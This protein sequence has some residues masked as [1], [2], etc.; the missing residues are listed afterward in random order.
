MLMRKF[1]VTE[2]WT[3]QRAALNRDIVTEKL[4][5]YG[6][7]G[8][9]WDSSIHPRFS[10]HN[11]ALRLERPACRHDAQGR[12]L[13]CHRL[14]K[15]C[16]P[17]NDAWPLQDADLC[18]IGYDTTAQWGR[19]RTMRC[20]HTTFSREPEVEAMVFVVM[21]TPNIINSIWRLP[22]FLLPRRASWFSSA[23]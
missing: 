16:E 2:Y 17:H 23:P 1:M 6:R 9:L 10:P 20:H 11:P 7:Y 14:V 19:Y 21:V 18:K 22:I 15:Q 13:S 4:G 5:A 12:I 3:R 8:E